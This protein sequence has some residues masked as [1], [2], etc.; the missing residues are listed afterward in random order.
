MDRKELVG[1]AE[2]LRC[3]VGELSIPYLGMKVGGRLL[4]MEGWG[5]LI[6][7]VKSSLRSR[8]LSLCQ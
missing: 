5:N 4:G 1:L 8:M 7:N 2:G 6:E 3:Q